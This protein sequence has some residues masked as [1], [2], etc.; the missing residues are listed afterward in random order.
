MDDLEGGWATKSNPTLVVTSCENSR[1]NIKDPNIP[2]VVKGFSVQ[3]DRF[4]IADSFFRYPNGDFGIGCMED[5]SKKI[6]MTWGPPDSELHP[7][8]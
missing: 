3:G 7:K 6:K 4:F 8:W 5:V 2:V 1:L